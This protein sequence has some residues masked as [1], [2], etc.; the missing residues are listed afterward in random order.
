M[1]SPKIENTH[2]K[3]Q[4]NP[5][6]SKDESIIN[7]LDVAVYANQIIIKKI[8]CYIKTNCQFILDYFL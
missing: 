4:I 1:P 8:V 6:N 3:V 2:K 7:R 5:K